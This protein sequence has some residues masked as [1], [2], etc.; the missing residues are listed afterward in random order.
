MEVTSFYG[1][2]MGFYC[3][4][5]DVFGGDFIFLLLIFPLFV[6]YS[7][8]SLFCS[9]P[10]P[11]FSVSRFIHLGAFSRQKSIIAKAFLSHIWLVEAFYPTLEATT[12]V[13]PSDSAALWSPI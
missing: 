9:N 6:P 13:A 7:A 11:N 4:Y 5:L 2:K 8:C 12:Q 3:F 1:L 10:F